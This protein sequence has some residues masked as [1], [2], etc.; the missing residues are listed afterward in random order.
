M[1]NR[2]GVSAE[3]RKNLEI[4]NCGFL[5]KAATLLFRGLET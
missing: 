4:E 2:S 5:P 3:R 1:N